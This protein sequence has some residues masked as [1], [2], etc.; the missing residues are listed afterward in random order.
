MK[1]ITAMLVVPALAVSML[2]GCGNNYYTEDST[3]FVLKDGKIV[4]TDVEE[5][6]QNTYNETELQEYVNQTIDAYNE[7]NGK[8]SVK[9]KKLSIN[10][11]KASLTLE[12]EDYQDYA[13]FNDIDFF[14]GTIA[15]ALAAGY[16]FSGE[17]AIVDGENINSCSENEIREL[18]GY[19]VVI[20]RN[21]VNL[22]VYSSIKYA[23]VENSKLLDEKTIGISKENN[24]LG[25]AVTS[26]E[27]DTQSQIV[28]TENTQKDEVVEDA[29]SIGE[30][31]LLVESAEDEKQKFEFNEDDM[32][33]SNYTDVYTYVIFK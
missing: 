25:E 30:D 7:T 19:N 2:C 18:S 26:T 16:D 21:N 8:G 5:F 20:I 3:V 27:A 14:E 11:G 1:K 13:K 12:Y 10:D 6:N 15:E 9:I 24:L 17:F 32:G 4:S 28:S 33:S 22:N 31:E 23:S 29:G